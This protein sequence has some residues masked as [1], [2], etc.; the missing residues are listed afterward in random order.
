MNNWNTIKTVPMF[1][2]NGIWKGRYCVDS[3]LTM[4]VHMTKGRHNL[5]TRLAC[6]DCV[7]TFDRVKRDKL[8]EILQRK[9]Y[10]IYN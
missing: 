9:L 2:Q 1:L 10:Q 5:K 8:F 6:I 4:K 3:S 7:I